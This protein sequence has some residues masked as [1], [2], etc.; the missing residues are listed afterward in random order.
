MTLMESLTSVALG[1][2]TLLSG[3]G[4]FVSGRKHRQEVKNLKADNRLKDME[5]AQLYVEQFQKNIAEPLQ[6][7]VRGLKDEVYELRTSLERVNDCPYRD[8]CPARRSDGGA[9]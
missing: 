8:I 4:W 5:L 1:M 9:V 3:C 6:R 7:E 2:L